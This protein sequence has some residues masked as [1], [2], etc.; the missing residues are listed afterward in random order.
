LKLFKE[1][2]SWDEI[3]KGNL[4]NSQPFFQHESLKKQETQKK[5]QR[6]LSFLRK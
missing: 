1:K 2:I 6:S 3:F 4:K 5:S